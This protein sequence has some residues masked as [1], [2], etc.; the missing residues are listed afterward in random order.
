M[1]VMEDKVRIKKSYKNEKVVEIYRDWFG[2]G[3]L[4]DGK[5]DCWRVC[6]SE[7]GAEGS[8]EGREESRVLAVP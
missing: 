8:E 5:G 1:W 7:Q 2:G 6:G 3:W 4:G